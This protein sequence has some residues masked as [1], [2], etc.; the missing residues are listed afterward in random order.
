MLEQKPIQKPKATSPVVACHL[1]GENKN[2]GRSCLV[3]RAQTTKKKPCKLIV[4]HASSVDTKVGEQRLGL[5][6]EFYTQT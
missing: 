4:H 5:R 1:N 6:S 2:S 3:V